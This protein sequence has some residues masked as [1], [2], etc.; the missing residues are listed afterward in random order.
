MISLYKLC[1]IGILFCAANLSLSVQAYILNTMSTNSATSTIQL[2]ATIPTIIS[3]TRNNQMQSYL[4]SALHQPE[5]M[6][7]FYYDSE[8]KR[9]TPISITG[10]QETTETGNQ[11]TTGIFLSRP[12]SGYRQL[13]TKP[14][15]SKANDE[16]P[17]FLKNYVNSNVSSQV[18]TT[19]NNNTVEVLVLFL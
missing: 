4:F 13:D 19:N 7:V 6:S 16:L 15:K 12:I 18:T 1:L 8:S 9:F 10:N 11:Q 3:W 17:E 2:S 14:V 5:N